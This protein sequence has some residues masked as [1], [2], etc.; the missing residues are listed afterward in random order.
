MDKFYQACFSRL[1]GSSASSGWQSVNLSP[2][3]P[4]RLK[5]WYERTERGN[6][7]AQ[8]D[9]PRDKNGNP[10]C[11]LE[12]LCDGSG[13]GISRV[14]YG[15]A[16]AV[17][18]EN[19]F[20]HGFL[21]QNAYELLKD[22]NR[23]LQIADDNF[24]FTAQET[25]RIP[26]ELLLAPPFTEEGALKLCQMDQ[27]KYAAYISCL[28]YALS[29]NTRIT[30]YVKTD[31]EDRTARAL[32]YL[33]YSAVPY[34]L[35]ARITAATYAGSSVRNA[36]LVF[37]RDCPEN[38]LYVEPSTGENNILTE[39][40]RN[41]WKRYPFVDYYARHYREL[42]G[43]KERFYGGIEDWLGKMG[44]PRLRDMGAVRL[45]FSM[46]WEDSGERPDLAAQL[47]EW[48]TLPV[49]AN[50]T[51]DNTVAGLLRQAVEREIDLGEDKEAL[52]AQRLQTSQSSELAEL[53]NRYRA[54]RLLR[55]APEQAR[56]EL[57]S[58][59]ESDFQQLRPLL[60]KN[61]AGLFILNAY[62]LKKADELEQ[63]EELSYEELKDFADSLLNLPKPYLNEV[64]SQVLILAG[65]I[66]NRQIENGEPIC[67]VEEQFTAFLNGLDSHGRLF[68]VEDREMCLWNFYR[69]YDREFREH[70]DPDRLEEYQEFYGRVAGTLGK[71]YQDIA[72]SADLLEKYQAAAKGD[73][74]TVWKYVAGGCVSPGRAC[75][76]EQERRAAE[77][78]LLQCALYGG[79]AEKCGSAAFW[80]TMADALEEEPVALMARHQARIFCDPKALEVSLQRDHDRWGNAE[81]LR[82]LYQRW[83]ALM[84][85]DPDAP[86]KKSGDVLLQEIKDRE[87]EEKRIQKE[88]DRLGPREGRDNKKRHSGKHAQ[89][90]KGAKDK[91]RE[92]DLEKKK[93]KKP[94]FFDE[95]KI[96]LHGFGRK[97]KK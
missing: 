43:K 70:F 51:L 95:V 34:S 80:F 15:L 33:A 25:E 8:H 56:D 52:L 26:E 71:K 55:M 89:S 59:P 16:D 93:Q 28:Y 91:A 4:Q 85:Q 14:Q 40:L 53:F 22:P 6:Q 78:S 75:L 67:S 86:C 17:G 74:E 1:G 41:R 63:R 12:I 83:Q 97:G 90:S 92:P 65:R 57:I 5:E 96:G 60:A 21:F 82:G 20:C 81:V 87:S 47:Y 2:G 29:T 42:K 68:P 88:L 19:M 54:G 77:N 9:T 72:R 45:A 62:Y 84:E 36:M 10:L 61:H 39:S 66:G 27:E 18:R 64:W 30:L 73:Y 3:I 46:A 69:L 76:S 7:P 31:G 58:L 23:I 35:R 11:M 13:V 24:H 94:N 44:D 48:L 79:A 38:C 49:P 32:L 37:G 50:E